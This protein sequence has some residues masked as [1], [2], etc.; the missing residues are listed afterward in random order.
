[1]VWDVFKSD[2]PDFDKR[3]T[4]LEFDRVLGFGLNNLSAQTV[5]P[6]EITAL[7]Q[8]REKARQAKKWDEADKLRK[9]V[10]EKGWIIED[11]TFGAHLKKAD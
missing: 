2:L 11:E 9:Q 5:V 1:V 3:S 6:E 10:L 4:L 7:V 8:A